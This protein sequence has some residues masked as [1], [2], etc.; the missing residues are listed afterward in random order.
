MNQLKIFENQA[1]GAVRTVEIDGEPWMV[2]KDIADALGYVNSRDAIAK[3]VNEED[4]GVAKC[5]TLGGPQDMVVINESGLYA[6][7]MGSTLPS[8]RQFKHW[9][10]HDVLPAIRKHGYYSTMPDTILMEKL[11]ETMD[12]QWKLDN[13]IIPTLRNGTKKQAILCAK[14]L[15]L[16]AEEF[17]KDQRLIKKGRANDNAKTTL[18]RWK[19]DG[20]RIYTEHDLPNE[21]Q[22]S[23]TVLGELDKAARANQDCFVSYCG[24]LYFNKFGYQKLIDRLVKRGY[25]T[26]EAASDFIRAERLV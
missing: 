3:Q 11:L 26:K 24:T 1:F 2:A 6:L 23:Y 7:I 20:M 15:G 10:T 13:V 16:S 18:D 9:V 22:E 25:M 21:F 19:M 4:K 14:V 5:D 8:A 17:E 12:D